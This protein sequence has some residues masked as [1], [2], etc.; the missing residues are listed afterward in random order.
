M[1]K[2]HRDMM[3][4]LCDIFPE[5]FVIVG[6]EAIPAAQKKFALNT[7]TPL[8][9]IDPILTGTWLD[10]PKKRTPKKRDGE[11][12]TRVFLVFEF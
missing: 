6:Q 4:H 8:F 5:N 11:R 1:S 2:E 10:P 3:G 12:D 7:N 9:K